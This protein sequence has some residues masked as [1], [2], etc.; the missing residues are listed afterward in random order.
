MQEGPLRRAAAMAGIV[1]VILLVVTTILT[2]TAPMPDKSAATIVKWYA[3]HRGA[4]LTSGALSGLWM[5]AFLVFLGYLYHLLSRAE[6]ARGVLASI[7]LTSGV[8]TDTI[9]A[10]TV[11]PSLALAVAASRPGVPT[12]DGL[13]HALADLNSFAALLIATGIGLFLVVAGLLIGDGA[14]APAWARWIAYVGAVLSLVGG[15]ASAF[16]SRSGKLNIGSLASFVGLGLFAIVVLA[17]SVSLFADRA[18]VVE[19]IR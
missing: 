12:S 17:V 4:V 7:L 9:A 13:V 8:A 16:V 2:I 11:L 15:V 18:P 14:L 19:P 5:V 10:V 1:F 3:G 6:G